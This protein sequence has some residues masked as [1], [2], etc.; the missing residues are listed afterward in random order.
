MRKIKKYLLFTGG[1]VCIILCII[2]IFIPINEGFRKQKIMNGVYNLKLLGQAMLVYQEEEKKLAEERAKQLELA[3]EQGLD[4]LGDLEL[5]SEEEK[6]ETSPLLSTLEI[7]DN[8]EGTSEEDLDDAAIFF[9]FFDDG[10][11]FV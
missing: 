3:K 2:G 6:V 7:I 1:A 9:D 10:G 5:L 4:V 8:K 11:V